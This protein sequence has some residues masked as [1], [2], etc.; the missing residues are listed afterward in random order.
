MWHKSEFDH[1]SGANLS[2]KSHWTQRPLWLLCTV[3]AVAA[4]PLTTGCSPELYALS[5][6]VVPLAYMHMNQ[7]GSGTKPNAFQARTDH[8]HIHTT[9]VHASIVHTA[10]DIPQPQT[11]SSSAHQDRSPRPKPAMPSLVVRGTLAYREMRW[12]DAE[13]FLTEAIAEGT[14]TDS[15]LSTAHMLLGAMEYQQGNPQAARTH[16]VAAY[17]YDRQMQLSPEVFPPH[18]V[19]FYRTVNDVEDP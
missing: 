17:R 11:S 10:H 3:A 12:D 15:E 18:L 19:D 6:I 2:T 13:R 16:F 4:L 7:G 14:S 1:H 9:P 5:A 8:S